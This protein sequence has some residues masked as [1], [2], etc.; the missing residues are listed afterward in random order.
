MFICTS[1]VFLW[2]AYFSCQVWEKS[3]ICLFFPR[4]CLWCF[5]MVLFRVTQLLWSG[6]IWLGGGVFSGW[7]DHNALYSSSNTIPILGPLGAVSLTALS[8]STG[9]KLSY[10][11]SSAEQRKRPDL[12]WGWERSRKTLVLI[13]AEGCGPNRGWVDLVFS[14]CL[15]WR[16]DRER[17]RDWL[18]EENSPHY[19]VCLLPLHTLAN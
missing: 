2:H 18:W 6:G 4:L 12:P 3:S 16:T 1:P 7:K 5:R 8:E 11:L 17:L 19:P 9:W 13:Y 10:Y 15:G 14:S